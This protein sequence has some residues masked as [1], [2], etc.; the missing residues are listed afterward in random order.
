MHYESPQD[1]NWI[2]PYWKMQ[3]NDKSQKTGIHV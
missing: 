1:S 3:A 2:E